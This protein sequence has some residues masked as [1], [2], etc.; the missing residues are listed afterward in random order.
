MIANRSPKK[1][2]RKNT[3]QMLSEAADTIYLISAKAKQV[4]SNRV[5]RS[6]YTIKGQLLSELIVDFIDEDFVDVSYQW[7]DG[8]PFVLVAV[9]GR[10][11]T[12]TFHVPENHLSSAAV[13]KVV[14]KTS[15]QASRA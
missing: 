1:T 14:F 13:A 10:P 9:Y 12:R 3:R 2:K 15:Q 8:R 6:L 7:I 4:K 11:T 5:C